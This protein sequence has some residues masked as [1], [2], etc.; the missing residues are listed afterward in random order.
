VPIVPLVAELA[1]H[2]SNAASLLVG[3]LLCVLFLL[4][5]LATR[6]RSPTINDQ[7]TP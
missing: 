6:V 2:Y 4:V 7:G 3:T 5:A 1:R